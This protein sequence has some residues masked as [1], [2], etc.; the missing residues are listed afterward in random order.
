MHNL[1]QLLKILIQAD[2]E[3]VLIGGYAG[4]V[5]GV[6]GLTR[7]LDIC[8]TM[9]T[10]NSGKLRQALKDYN[11]K[12]R[13]NPGFKPSFL[14]E[15]KTVENLNAIYLQTDLGILDVLSSVVSVGDY[16]TL[17]NESVE[18]EVF[19]EFCRVISLDHLIK[20]KE[21]MSRDKD[22]VALKELYAIREKLLKS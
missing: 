14:D 1:N 4:V 18:I 12:H 8:A 7:D 9:T 10:E 22:K 13:M 17:K 3:F 21:K 5:H 20:A 19:G 11:P 16:Q 6:T 15:P 2:I